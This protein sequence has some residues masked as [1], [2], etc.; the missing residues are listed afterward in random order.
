M[1]EVFS[2]LWE[3]TKKIVKSISDVIQFML[4]VAGSMALLLL[5]AI[6]LAIALTVFFAFILVILAYSIQIFCSI[7]GLVL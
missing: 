3:G 6:V 5:M 7:F 4:G 1:K 2:G